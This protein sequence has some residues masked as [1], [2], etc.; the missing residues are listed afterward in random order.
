MIPKHLLPS[1]SLYYDYIEAFLPSD[2][3]SNF[4]RPAVLVDQ[5][6]DGMLVR[7][8]LV[9][10]SDQFKND[11]NVSGRDDGLEARLLID[12]RPN[13]VFS[14]RSTRSLMRKFI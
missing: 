1:S 2:D 12:S 11:W 8:K 5:F 4:V 9:S 13:D 10:E 14:I 3:S 7:S 6:F